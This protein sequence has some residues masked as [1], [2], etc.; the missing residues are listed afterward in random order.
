MP[1][2]AC[3]PVEV[4][5]TRNGL[6]AF[7]AHFLDWN[8]EGKE[9][10]VRYF[11]RSFLD[12]DREEILEE[13]D[14]ETLGKPEDAEGTISF[15]ASFAWSAYSCTVEGY[16]QYCPDKLITLSEACVQD[17]VSV[18]IWTEEPGL[19]FEEEIIADSDGVVEN[20]CRELKTVRCKHCGSLQS[21]S[22]FDDPDDLECWEC[23]E[24]DFEIIEQE[25]Q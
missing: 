2:W 9:H 15:C 6:L 19:C 5:G 7:V 13:I 21:I 14:L 10:K 22:S 25:E 3:G 16:P 23:G 1:N 8:A 12:T 24:S 4:T 11:A 20:H 17:Q 18:H